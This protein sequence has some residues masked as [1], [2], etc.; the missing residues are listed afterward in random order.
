MDSAMKI[1]LISMLALGLATPSWAAPTPDGKSEPQAS[2]ENPNEI[3]CRREPVVGSLTKK[4]KVCKTRAEWQ[5]RNK[6][7][8]DALDDLRYDK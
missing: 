7:P 1:V 4:I 6:A 5:G 2:Q 8:G 3:I